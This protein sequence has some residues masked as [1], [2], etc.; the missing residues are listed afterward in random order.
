M[1]TGNTETSMRLNQWHEGK[2]DALD[3]LL[4]R[5]LPWLHDQV[6][7]RLSPLLRKKGETVDYVQD[8]MVNFLRFGPRFI[9]SDEAHFRALLLKIAE[10]ALH[11]R[12]DWFIARRRDIAKE[13]PLPADTVLSLDPP[14][15]EIRT[16]SHMADQY[17][18]EAWIRMGMEFLDPDEREVLLMRNWEKLSFAEIGERFGISE[19]AAWMKHNRATEKL[20]DKVWYLRSGK[21]ARLLED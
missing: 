18:R 20:G 15:D 5:N 1:K 12:Y 6:R 10:N 2:V 21:L 9:I 19:N 16:P 17:E 14:R 4:E 7:K 8:A 11:D 13:R 3:A